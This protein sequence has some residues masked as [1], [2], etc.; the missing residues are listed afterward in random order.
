MACVTAVI[1]FQTR[2]E[3]K[4]LLAEARVS[5]NGYLIR[6]HLTNFH[7]FQ[8]KYH[9][10]DFDNRL[11]MRVFA[12]LKWIEKLELEEQAGPETEVTG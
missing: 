4:T 8:D 2:A 6:Y 1:A 11:S 7:C 5:P 12:A 10:C 3:A 9:G